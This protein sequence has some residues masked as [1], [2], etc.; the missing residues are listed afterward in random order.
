MSFS[1]T[2]SPVLFPAYGRGKTALWLEGSWAWQ[3]QCWVGP[4]RLW[5]GKRWAGARV[6]RFSVH[7]GSAFIIQRAEPGPGLSRYYTRKR[8]DS[9]FPSSINNL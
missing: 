8:D 9:F 7:I 4:L 5:D 1:S 3:R 2:Q 6:P